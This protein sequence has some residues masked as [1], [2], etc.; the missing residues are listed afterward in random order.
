MFASGRSAILGC[1][2]HA[3]CKKYPRVPN[4][5]VAGRAMLGQLQHVH[6]AGDGLQRFQCATS[7][8]HA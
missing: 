8:S 2:N 3:V 7:G 6:P 4:Q 5:S 1:V